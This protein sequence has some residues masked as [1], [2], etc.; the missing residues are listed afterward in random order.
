MFADLS[1]TILTLALVGPCRTVEAFAHT[2]P[3]RVRG[4]ALAAA[5]Q[6]V[7]AEQAVRTTQ[8]VRS[9]QAVRPVQAVQTA[10][11][12]DSRRAAQ[13]VHA[14]GSKT[15]IKGSTC[16]AQG[17]AEQA[18][19]AVDTAQACTQHSA[20]GHTAQAVH[21]Q[22]MEPTQA[23]GTKEFSKHRCVW[24]EPQTSPVKV[25][26]RHR[27]FLPPRTQTLNRQRARLLNK[28]EVFYTD[29]T[30]TEIALSTACRL[31]PGTHLLPIIAVAP[32]IL[33]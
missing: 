14:V 20:A 33:G 26:H 21:R 6:A 30:Q 28:T 10:Q 23:A 3:R 2:T 17:A 31:M 12:T 4:N 5:E 9:E 32:A 7:H 16:S 27:T 11:L 24:L 19:Q 15:R 25:W 13:A 8:A 1:V 18:A 29:S 22:C